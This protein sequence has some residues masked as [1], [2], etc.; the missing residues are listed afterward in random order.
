MTIRSLYA[1][2]AAV[3]LLCAPAAFAGQVD[4]ELKVES[5]ASASADNTYGPNTDT[6]DENSDAWGKAVLKKFRLRGDS[7]EGQAEGGY[8]AR[9]STN[10]SGSTDCGCDDNQES[11]SMSSGGGGGGGGGGESTTSA[12]ASGGF[13]ASGSTD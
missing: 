6:I 5:S 11:A 7:A 13:S 3:A 10:S 1:A 2:T 8:N 12:S 9:A 4:I